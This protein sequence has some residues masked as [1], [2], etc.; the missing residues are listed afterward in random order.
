MFARMLASLAC[1]CLF[2]GLF[3][4]LAEARVNRR[5]SQPAPTPPPVAAP[6][7]SVAASPAA[8]VCAPVVCCPRDICYRHHK[9]CGCF[10]PC[11]TTQIILQVKDP[12]ACCVVEVPVCVPV[13]CAAKAPTVCC[14]KGFLR[15]E[16]VEYSWDCGFCLKVVFDRCG[17]ITVHYYGI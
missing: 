1:V 6:A 9:G 17:D 15:R 16:V 3:V 14:H 13:C 4:S 7:A 10:D 11:K 8:A 5:A 2:S 12:C